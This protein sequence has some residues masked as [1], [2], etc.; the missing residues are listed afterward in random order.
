MFL[1]W[2]EAH[3]NLEDEQQRQ[4]SK[5][6]IDDLISHTVF[7]IFDSVI[8]LDIIIPENQDELDSDRMN[9]SYA[10]RMMVMALATLNFLMPSLGLYR[11]SRTHFGEKYAKLRVVNENTG[12]PTTRGLDISII[13]HMLRLFA[14]NVPYLAIRI[15]TA[16]YIGKDMSIFILKNI[17]G[18]WVALRYVLVADVTIELRSCYPS[19]AHSARFVS[20]RSFPNA[21]NGSK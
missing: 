18:I 13:H 17:L 16:K 5:T 11:L 12:L 1:L 9:F 20:G 8:F 2:V 4:L 19:V 3:R 21:R 15:H 14:I 6:C 10:F 7:E